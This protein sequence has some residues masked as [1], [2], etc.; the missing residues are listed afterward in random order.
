MAHAYT[1][2]LK[3]AAKINIEKIRKL[4]LLGD[5]LVKKDDEIPSNTIVAKTELPGKVYP[6]NVAGQLALGK[7]SELPEAMLKKEGDEVEK[8]EL[9]AQSKGFF[10]F[11]KQQFLVRFYVNSVLD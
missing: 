3:V 6:I 5:V 2:G 4:P 7:A 9:I 11:F 10:G 1:P 8:G